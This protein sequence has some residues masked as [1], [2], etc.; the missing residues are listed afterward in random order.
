MGRGVYTLAA[1]LSQSAYQLYEYS[2]TLPLPGKSDQNI[3]T[4]CVENNLGRLRYTVA[5][6]ER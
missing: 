5:L 2:P 1:H 6:T 3:N 4:V